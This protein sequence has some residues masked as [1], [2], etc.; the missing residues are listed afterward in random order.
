M[1]NAEFKKYCLKEQLRSTE[2]RE[3]H[4]LNAKKHFDLPQAVHQLSGQAV[5]KLSGQAVHELIN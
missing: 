1:Y 4:V 2:K 3:L 5:H